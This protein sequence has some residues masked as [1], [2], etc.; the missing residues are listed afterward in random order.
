MNTSASETPFL[1]GE[2]I[3]DPAYAGA[4]P[5]RCLLVD[6]S[7]FDRSLMRYSAERS[8]VDIE[9]VDAATLSEARDYL[10]S[11]EFDLLILDQRL[12]DGDG[13]QLADELASSHDQ[14][15]TIM[16]SGAESSDLKE[17]ARLAGCA[18]FLAKQNLSPEELARVVGSVLAMQHVN[19]AEP[20]EQPLSPEFELMMRAIGNASKASRQRPLISRLALL[21]EDLRQETGTAS[22]TLLDEMSE[23]C[24]T[25]WAET[26]DEHS[27][28]GAD[29]M[30]KHIC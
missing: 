18:E 11:G 24:A 19:M 16:V 22:T 29:A 17:D 15:P 27:Q 2:V 1:S 28:I 25:L 9:F 20:A 21:V 30:P 13:L 8:N 14:L 4:R 6:D 3:S 23:I 26:E 10:S 7:Q 5:I 12:P